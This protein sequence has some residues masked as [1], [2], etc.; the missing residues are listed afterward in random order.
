MKHDDKQV[1]KHKGSKEQEVI[2]L[3]SRVPQGLA[4]VRFHQA[5]SAKAHSRATRRVPLPKTVVRKRWRVRHHLPK[6]VTRQT[7]G[8]I[9]TMSVARTVHDLKNGVEITGISQIHQRP[10]PTCQASAEIDGSTETD[11]A[12]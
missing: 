1:N 12:Y 2:S 10:S 4:N 8:K 7:G 6:P 3:N 5:E 9:C 11:Q